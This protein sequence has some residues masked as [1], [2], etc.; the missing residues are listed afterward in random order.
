[1]ELLSKLSQVINSAEQL[2]NRTVFAFSSLIDFST[3]TIDLSAKIRENIQMIPALAWTSDDIE[4]LVRML[5]KELRRD[6]SENEVSSVVVSAA[7]LPR[8]VKLLFRHYRN[9]VA[10]GQTLQQMLQRVRSELL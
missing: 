4:R 10:E 5:A 8:F 3:H 7:G 1:M 9:G 6:L 2:E